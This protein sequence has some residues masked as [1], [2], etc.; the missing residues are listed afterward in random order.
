MFECKSVTKL[1]YHKSLHWWI[2]FIF[3]DFL[4]VKMPPLLT[5]R[6]TSCRTPNPV[7]FCSNMN[8]VTSMCYTGS[9]V[10]SID[11]YISIGVGTSVLI[12]LLSLA[13]FLVFV[14]ICCGYLKQKQKQT[15][16][17]LNKINLPILKTTFLP[18]YIPSSNLLSCS[19][20][21]MMT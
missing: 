19:S 5:E 13:A 2:D 11:V 9:Q 15:N 6:C 16:N 3:K 8:T 21:V 4:C 12:L 18:Y 1:L 17:S 7:E 10:T 20:Q 14:C